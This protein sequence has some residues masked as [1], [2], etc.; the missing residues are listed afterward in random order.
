MIALAQGRTTKNN[1]CL[2]KHSTNC[3]AEGV[4]QRG[5]L[6]QVQTCSKKYPFEIGPT[7]WEQ[8]VYGIIAV[9]QILR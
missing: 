2:R 4:V 1:W 8:G 7:L 3:Y 6:L 5:E 9:I